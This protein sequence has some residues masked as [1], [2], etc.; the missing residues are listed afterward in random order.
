MCADYTALCA[1]AKLLL[2]T[3]CFWLL[4]DFSLRVKHPLTSVLIEIQ[5]QKNVVYPLIINHSTGKLD[6][7]IIL[8]FN[9][10][11]KLGMKVFTGFLKPFAG[12]REDKLFFVDSYGTFV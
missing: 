1:P 6:S 11:V 7:K 9:E 2:P 12:V 4:Y 10:Q 8:G 5:Q 3:N